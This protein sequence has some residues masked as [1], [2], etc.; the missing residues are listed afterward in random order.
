MTLM[1]IIRILDASTQLEQ[2]G[3]W[4]P[5][6]SSKGPGSRVVR[7]PRICKINLRETESRAPD[8][9]KFDL[10]GNYKLLPHQ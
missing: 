7:A 3:A 2:G 4:S 9:A 5:N 8:R 10:G 6:F 1:K